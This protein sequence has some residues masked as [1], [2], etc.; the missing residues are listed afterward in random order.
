MKRVIALLLAVLMI[1][2]GCTQQ[3]VQNQTPETS[4]PVE[5][6]T[7]SAPTTKTEQVTEQGVPVFA[8]DVEPNFAALSDPSLLQYVEDNIYSD[9]VARFDSENYIVESVNAVYVSE[10]YLEEVAYNSKSNVY[11]GYTLEELDA[12]F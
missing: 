10:E 7:S 6:E 12:Q 9:L 5:T 2:T 1:L 11:F 8:E 4:T 3:T